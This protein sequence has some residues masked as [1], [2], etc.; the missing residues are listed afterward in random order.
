MSRQ[1]E[2]NAP[3]VVAEVIDGE[4]VI[5]NLESGHYFSARGSG[6]LVWEWLEQGHS[7]ETVAAV[8]SERHAASAAE[9]REQV[10]KF[11]DELVANQL[12]RE[13]PASAAPLDAVLDAAGAPEE[14]SPPTLSTY[15][16]MEDLLLLDPIH[17]VGAAGWPMPKTD[18]AV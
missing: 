1:F 9:V 11:V 5:M 15:T 2:I 14:W 3:S 4:A 6:A 16:D 12:V 18:E 17:D 10:T 8:L 13:A 7:T